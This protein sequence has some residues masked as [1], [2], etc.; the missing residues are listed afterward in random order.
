MWQSDIFTFCPRLKSDFGAVR[1]NWL[2]LFKAPLLPKAGHKIRLLRRLI[3][4]FRLRHPSLELA[5]SHFV[6][7][8]GPQEG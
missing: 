7:R 5:D 8:V 3:L 6:G 2:G 4:G 1:A